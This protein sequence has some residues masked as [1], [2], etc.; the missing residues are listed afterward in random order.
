MVITAFILCSILLFYGFTFYAT[1]YGVWNRLNLFVKVIYSPVIIV[2]GVADVL[3]DTIFGTVIYLELPGWMDGRI[4]FSRRCEYHMQDTGFRGK[5]AR[6]F[7]KLLN[8]IMPGH[9]KQ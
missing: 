2:F 8:T 4:T 9:C 7:C 6:T 5:I 3:Y 1:V